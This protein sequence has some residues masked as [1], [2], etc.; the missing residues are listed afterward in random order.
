MNGQELHRVSLSRSAVR[1]LESVDPAELT[2]R[3]VF[4]GKKPGRG[5]SNMAMATVLRRMGEK[6]ATVGSG[7]PIRN[8]WRTS[9][10]GNIHQEG[11]DMIETN[12]DRSIAPD[13][14]CILG[15]EGREGTR[16]GSLQRCPSRL[17]DP[18]RRP[19]MAAS[20]R[21]LSARLGSRRLVA[22]G[23]GQLALIKV[24]A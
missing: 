24:A 11:A 13:D 1:L 19:A 2:E 4:T 21:P 3:H 10:T 16:R 18:G 14:G 20:G 9:R 15:G 22:G 7:L 6:D 17:G 23:A 12:S 8:L 5:L